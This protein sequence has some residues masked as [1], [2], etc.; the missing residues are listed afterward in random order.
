MSRIIEGFWNCQYCGE[1]RIRGGSQECPNCGKARDEHTTFELDEAN[2]HYVPEKEAIHISRNPD[3]ICAFCNQLN[4]SKTMNCK[5]CGA[6]RTQK[7]LD[8]F[9]NKQKQGK[10]EQLKTPREETL[11]NKSKLNVQKKLHQWT[12]QKLLKYILLTIGSMLGIALLIFILLPKEQE[13]TIQEMKWKRTISIDKYQT[14]E[15]SSWILPAGARL[16]YAQ[17][18]FS[19]YEKV[20]DHYETKTKQVLK[21]RIVGYEEYVTGTRDLGNGY[22]EETTSTRPVY[23][24]YYDT[25]SYEE[26][27]YREEAVYQIKYYYEID[28]WIYERSVVTEGKDKKPYWGQTNL[29]SDEKESSKTES[30]SIIGLNKK[31]KKQTVLLSY[32]DWAILKIGD[33]VK[34]KVSLGYGKVVK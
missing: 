4:S 25:E 24:E 2:K 23:E 33:T 19:H 21:Q 26:P 8:Y 22:F 29:K 1:T 30:Y 13:I 15:E 11:E 3:W 17:K 27:V 18:E 7:S 32:N 28:K 6:S 14:V 12:T 10:Q 16:K 34:L 31:E 9:E 5:F 20:I